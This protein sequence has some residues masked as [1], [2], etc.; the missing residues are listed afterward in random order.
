MKYLGEAARFKVGVW[1]SDSAFGGSLAFDSCDGFCQGTGERVTD[2]ASDSAFPSDLLAAGISRFIFA[3]GADS[4][5]TFVMPPPAA[6]GAVV[7][8]GG[9]ARSRRT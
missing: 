8:A 4:K 1:E 5:T 6:E 7:T 3:G 9:A 2:A